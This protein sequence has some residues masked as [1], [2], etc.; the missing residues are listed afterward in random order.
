MLDS[1]AWRNI[2]TRKLEGKR[3]RVGP[4]EVTQDSLR[5]KNISSRKLEGKM[6]K[7][8]PREIVLECGMSA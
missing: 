8:T 5:W 3:A 1:V 6:A 4:T 7:V 2:S